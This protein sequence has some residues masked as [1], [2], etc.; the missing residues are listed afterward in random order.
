MEA[1]GGPSRAL[2]GIVES[3][4][5]I[6]SLIRVGTV[7]RILDEDMIVVPVLVDVRGVSRLSSGLSSPASGGPL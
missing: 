5:V 2:V 6:K 4:V 3:S 7:V 1:A